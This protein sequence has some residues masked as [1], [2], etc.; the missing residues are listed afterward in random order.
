MKLKYDKEFEQKGILLNKVPPKVIYY[1][2]DT[3]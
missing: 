1:S 2:G 3:S